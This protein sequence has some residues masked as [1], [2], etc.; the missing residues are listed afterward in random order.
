MTTFAERVIAPLFPGYFNLVMATGIVSNG[1]FLLG[2]DVLSGVLLVAGFVAFPLLLVALVLRALLYPRRLWADLVDPRL[3][4]TFFTLVAATDVLGSGL[5]LRGDDGAAT[6]L[7]LFAL[8]VWV[9]LG[10]LSFSVLT[11]VNN[12]SG[13]EVVHG[14][15]LIAIVGTESLV[16]LGVLLAPRFGSLRDLAQITVYALW[17][18]GIVFYGIFITLFTH[19]IFFLRL[20]PA[21]MGPLFWVVMGAAAISTNAGSTLIETP[22]ALPFL[23]AMRPFVDGTTLI[24]WAWGT[25]WIPLL[26][27]LGVWRHVV[28][29]FP[30]RYEPGY[31]NL[32][33]PLG[34]YT[35]ATFRLSLAADY[36]AL[37]TVARVMI[38]VAFAA[39]LATA[40]G[41][42]SVVRP[43]YRPRS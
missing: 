8:V 39:W 24:L 4:F 19:R 41:L 21:E 13:A 18:I 7:W 22:P 25:W 15:W 9:V 26:V 14:G 36:T 40:A 6:G 11:F 23:Q 27:I 10:Y 38:W 33:F 32:V 34:M 5:H 17:G 29:R 12:E 3:V 30:L 31:W 28:R 35:V 1:F 2:H 42:V 37:Q 20:E 43:R 16:I